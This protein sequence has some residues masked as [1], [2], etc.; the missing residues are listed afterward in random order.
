MRVTRE[1]TNQTAPVALRQVCVS[2][3]GVLVLSDIDVHVDRGEAVAL[4]GANG[5]GKST[6]IRAMLGLVPSGGEIVLF[7]TPRQRFRDWSRVGYVPQRSAGSLGI[8]TVR[9]VVASGRLPRRTPL[10]PMSAADRRAVDE[11]LDRVGLAN[12]GRDEL[13][14]LSGGQQQRVLI[15]RALVGEPE[16]MVLD[17]PMAGVDLA[18]QGQLT[19]VLA[20]L[21][22]EGMA[23]LV[24]LHELG[25]LNR[26][27]D[28]AIVLGEGRVVHDG[29]P[30]LGHRDGHEHVTE[31][32]TH[33][34]VD[35]PLRGGDA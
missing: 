27:M 14:T 17:E 32:S 19:E 9:E 28:R 5:S 8:A 25:P 20:G 33:A 29:E 15:A 1:S 35:H 12:R 16:L 31:I 30:P 18:T 13:A 11:A 3:G 24:V 21:K 23:M 7:G 34:I 4:M 10:L 26:L 6:L 22:A 2:L